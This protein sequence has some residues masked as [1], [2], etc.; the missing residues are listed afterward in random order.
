MSITKDATAT[1]VYLSVVLYINY[2]VLFKG[3]IQNFYSFSRDTISNWLY[4]V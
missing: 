2:V 3:E 4:F 1:F